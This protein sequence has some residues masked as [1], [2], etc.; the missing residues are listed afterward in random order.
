VFCS[1]LTSRRWVTKNLR[2]NLFLS[3]K[4]SR[5]KKSNTYVFYATYILLYMSFLWCSSSPEELQTRLLLYA[6]DSY[7]NVSAAAKEQMR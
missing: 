7:A 5:S 6:E 4:R 2:P 1:M 3:R